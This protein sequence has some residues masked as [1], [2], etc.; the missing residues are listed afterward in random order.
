LRTA[1]ASTG[2]A[3]AALAAVLLPVHA[4]QTG[5]G[6]F[7]GSAEGPAIRYSS[8]PPA[9]SIERLNAR[10]D[11]G[12]A[13]LT[14]QSTSGYLK[15]A[16]DAIG[17]RTDS[18]LLVFSDASFQARRINETNPRAIFFKDDVQ[19]G[20]VR[21]GDVIEVAAQDEKLGT[22]FYTLEQKAAAAPRFK[23][24]MV[25]L[26]CHMTGGTLDVPGLVLF[27]SGPGA[28]RPFGSVEYMKTS[29]PMAERFGGWFVTGESLPREHRGNA[30]RALEGHAQALRST[31]GLYPSDG[32]LAQTSDITA[33]LVFTHQAQTQ[34]LMIRADWEARTRDVPSSTRRSPSDVSADR[35]VL[36]SA[37]SDLVDSLLFTD[38]SPLET[39]V[40]G[41]S[42]FAERFATEGPRDRQGRSLRELDLKRRLMRYPCSYL[43]YSPLFDAMTP[44]M[45]GLVYERLWHVLS[46]AV[47]G[48]RYRRVLT[49]DDRRA[50][51]DILRATK[52]G[53]PSYFLGVVK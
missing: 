42:G 17:L 49:Q 26:G 15:S 29:T 13:H 52:P 36:R 7:Q 50:I 21:G 46:G 6:T 45:K 3:L 16:L 19:L 43:I 40:R 22:V 4:Q 32:Y 31:S 18:Q 48:P 10:L 33:L 25:C 2:L 14:F 51:V 35:E 1:L 44:L 8:T 38:E 5:R 27:S 30:V 39:P 53:L 20:W 24:A 47:T 34:N 23:R 28:G 37:A 12:A 41:T 9:N 11:S